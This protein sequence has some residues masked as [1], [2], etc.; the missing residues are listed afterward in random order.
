MAF[1][2]VQIADTGWN[3]SEYI[4]TG[5]KP[6]CRHYGNTGTSGA[7]RAFAGLEKWSFDNAT[8]Q[9][10]LDYTMQDG[11][12][13]GT[14]HTVGDYFPTASDGLRNITGIVNADGSV[15]IYGVTS[16]V[17]TSGDK[18]PVPNEIVAITDALAATTLPTDEMFSIHRRSAIWR[19]LSRDRVRPAQNNR[20]VGLCLC[21]T[22]CGTPAQARLV[23]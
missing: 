21:R 5:R 15:T 12:G 20:P 6:R 23:T 16:T 7:D 13:L 9:W 19:R 17:S 11:L 1:W 18:G 22:G 14:Y 2:R 4:G 10:V 8:G 3:M